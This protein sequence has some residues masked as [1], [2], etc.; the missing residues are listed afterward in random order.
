MTRVALVGAG[1]HGQGHLGTMMKMNGSEVVGVCDLNEALVTKCVNKWGVAGFADYRQMFEETRPEAVVIVTPPEVRLDVVSEAA[2]R[3]IHC[4]IEKPPAKDL[5]AARAVEAVLA[6]TGVIN[7]VGFMFRYGRAVD[8]LRELIAGR[9]VALVRSTMLDGIA[10]RPNWPRWF[11]DKARSGGL[12]F[13]QGIHVLDLSRYILGEAAA[14]TGLQ[15][16]PIIP[17]SEG[18]NVEE[19]ATL[20]LQWQSGVMHT[21]THSWTYPKFLAQIE[22][23]S[24]ELHLTLDLGKGSVSGF[25]GEEEVRFEYQD[26]LYQMELEA[27]FE[28]VR[29]GRRELVRSTYADSVTSLALT[30]SAVQSLEEGRSVTL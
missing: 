23:I 2:R 3:G 22:V 6:E 18:F 7:S 9:R 15:G 13:D 16:N 12:I 4:F 10:L 19:N 20:M 14:V 25:I 28:A 27:F 30:L 1:W 26:A 21:H 29:T 5:E 11:F 24:D 8:K 17:K